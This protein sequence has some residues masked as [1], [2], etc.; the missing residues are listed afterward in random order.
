MRH[1]GNSEKKGGWII[2]QAC[3][4][5]TVWDAVPFRN[6]VDVMHLHVTSLPLYH[7]R[8]GWTAINL[9]KNREVLRTKRISQHRK[10]NEI[11]VYLWARQNQKKHIK[12]QA[13]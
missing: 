2:A 9:G 7:H 1:D 4:K 5:E 10:W 8:I 12:H 3:R 11:S 13:M 6:T